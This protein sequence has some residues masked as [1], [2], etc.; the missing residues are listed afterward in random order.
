M[1][2]QPTSHEGEFAQR[3]TILVVKNGGRSDGRVMVKLNWSVLLVDVVR[4]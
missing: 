1:G 2:F 4:N 3:W